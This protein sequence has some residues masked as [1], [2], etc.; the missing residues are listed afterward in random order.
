MP[1][2]S[3]VEHLVQMFGTLHPT[4][5]VEADRARRASAYDGIDEMAARIAAIDAVRDPADDAARPAAA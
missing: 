2:R 5:Q 1:I 3:R 4:R